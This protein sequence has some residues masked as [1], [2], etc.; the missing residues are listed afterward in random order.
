M[1][2]SLLSRAPLG[3]LSAASIVL[4]VA[5]PALTIGDAAPVEQRTAATSPPVCDITDATITWGF[6]ESFRSYISGSI[7]K[8]AWEPFGG[9]GYETPAFT[10]TGG[11][12][13]Y[14]P[15]TGAGSIAFPG[16][17]RFTG[18]GGLLDSTVQNVTLEIA[19]AAGRVLVDLAG[20]S[21]ES[22]LAGDDT[23]VTTPQVPFVTVDLAGLENTVSGE[24]LTLAAADA[25]TAI[26]EEGF[27]AFGNYETGTAFDPLSFTASGVCAAATPTADPSPVVDASPAADAA[28]AGDDESG[29]SG[30]LPVALFAAIGGALV[31]TIGGST[32][33]IVASRRKQRKARAGGG[34]ADHADEG[35]AA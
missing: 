11:T 15:A 13:S 29:S 20:V 4:G 25:A 33:A 34:P 28:E 23:V 2:S 17:I 8:G 19:P 5:S 1:R 24:A 35:P 12:G 30:A 9:V 7:A 32:A 16:G 3:V 21:M 26:T 27:A 18:H 31:A 10:W 6:K 14:D 22:A